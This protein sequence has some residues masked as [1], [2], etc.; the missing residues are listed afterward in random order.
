V[1]SQVVAAAGGVRRD[2][3]SGPGSAVAKW[4]ATG[5]YERQS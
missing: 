2:A 5:N 4:H 3:S 1:R